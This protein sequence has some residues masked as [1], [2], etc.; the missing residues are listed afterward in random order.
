MEAILHTIGIQYN[1][2][3]HKMETQNSISIFLVDDNELFTKTLVLSL[4]DHFK[5]EIQIESFLTGEG[6]LERIQQ[7]P[8]SAA[9]V[10]ILDYHLNTESKEAMNGIEVL[11]EIKKINSKIIVIIL[12]AE[13][14]VTIALDSITNG[15]YEYVVKSET[16]FIRI[17]NILKNSLEKELNTKILKA[18]MMIMEKY[19]ELSKY[20]EEMPET[21][22]DENDPEVTLK[23]LKS[24][25][26]SL[27][28]LLKKYVLEHPAVVP[29]L[30]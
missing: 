14:K 16:A 11:K 1:L 4:K 2:K 27:D 24:Y 29:H 5:S 22:P 6:C 15:A 9:D 8:E 7:K 10:V 20:I 18:T 13:D 25:Y 30:V 3:K 12:S 26:N 28:S 23:N 19:P 17:R 21:I